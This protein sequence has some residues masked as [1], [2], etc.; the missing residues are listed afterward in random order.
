MKVRGIYRRSIE[1][2]RKQPCANGHS[3]QDATVSTTS[4]GKP[5]LRCRQCT[6]DSRRRAA[7]RKGGDGPTL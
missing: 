2:R 5:Y 4:D 6:R 1:E 7:E 3:R